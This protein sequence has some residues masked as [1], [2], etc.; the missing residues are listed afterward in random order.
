MRSASALRFSSHPEDNKH[1]NKMI[2]SKYLTKRMLILELGTSHI[3]GDKLK[4][5]TN[6]KSSELT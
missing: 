1:Y 5:W 3:V 2:A 4:F 6:L